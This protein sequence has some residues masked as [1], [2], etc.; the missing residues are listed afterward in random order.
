MNNLSNKNNLEKIGIILFI[1]SIIYLIISSYIG[2]FEANM[3]Y[4]ELYS[5]NMANMPIVSMITAG[6][7]NVHPL[8]YYF[9]LKIFVKIF[10]LFS[11]ENLEIIGVIVSLIP[12]YLLLILSLTKIRKNFG[13]LC[14]GI[15]SLCIISMPQLLRYSIEVRMYG[16][17]LFFLTASYV[18]IYEIN[19]ESDLKKW[20]ILTV[21]TICSCYTHYFAAVASF[22]LYMVFL[23]HILSKNRELL[24]MWLF[25]GIT[26]VLSYIPWIPPLINQIHNVGSSYWIDPISANTIIGYIYYIFSPLHNYI[27]GNSVIYPDIIGTILLI[28]FIILTIHYIKNIDEEIGKFPIYGLI[29]AILVPIIG[30]II[31]VLYSPIFFMR[32]MLPIFG[33]IWLSFSIFLDNIKDKK[34]FF[35]I[36]LIIILII[37][38]INLANFIS[39]ENTNYHEELAQ[40]EVYYQNIP[41]G[42]IIVYDGFN[43]YI[44]S[45]VLK[46]NYTSIFLEN[47]QQTWKSEKLWNSNPSKYLDKVFDEKTMKNREKNTDIYIVDTNNKYSELKESKYSLENVYTTDELQIYKINNIK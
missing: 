37:G 32:Y 6:A 21:L 47:L 28:T 25:S 14:S 38:T 27:N 8:L 9:I 44:K 46:N 5:L 1:L 40:K 13:L 11:F 2:I 30:V 36:A 26:V 31:S 42:S 10:G 29:A 20:I 24:K 4:D 23:I 15:F 22:C 12:F 3:W 16:W 43:S 33:I 35:T 7:N 17:A 19:K 41:A 45:N 39:T 34:A 18:Y